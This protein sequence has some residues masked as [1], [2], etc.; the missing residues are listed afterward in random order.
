MLPLLRNAHIAAN[1]IVDTL[2]DLLV[3]SLVEI[4]YADL[5]VFLRVAN[6]IWLCGRVAPQVKLGK[7]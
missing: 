7:H 6:H 5:L 1:E 3:L 2:T 4:G